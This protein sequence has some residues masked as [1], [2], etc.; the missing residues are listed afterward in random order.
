M[1]ILVRMRKAA[2]GLEAGVDAS[3]SPEKAK[4]LQEAGL[5]WVT[6]GDPADFEN[7]G[8]VADDNVG[9]SSTDTAVLRDSGNAQGG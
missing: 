7:H 5:A 4:E 1:A 2:E 9:P 8:I 3:V 6:G